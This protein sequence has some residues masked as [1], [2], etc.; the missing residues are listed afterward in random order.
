MKLGVSVHM[1]TF[2]VLWALFKITK[3]VVVVV[4]VTTFELKYIRYNYQ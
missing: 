2:R 1:G 3:M 4:I